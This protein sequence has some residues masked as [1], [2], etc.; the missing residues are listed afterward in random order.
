MLLASAAAAL[1]EDSH[2]G[3]AYTVAWRRLVRIV[4]LLSNARDLFGM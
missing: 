4:A 2:H 1:N 3:V